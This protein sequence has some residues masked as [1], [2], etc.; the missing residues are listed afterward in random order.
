MYINHTFSFA[1]LDFLTLVGTGAGSCGLDFDLTVY[2]SE[3]EV[4]RG[5]GDDRCFR[6]I[7]GILC[8]RGGFSGGA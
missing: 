6:D 7:V 4:T 5:F 1:F 8:V 3:V 2:S